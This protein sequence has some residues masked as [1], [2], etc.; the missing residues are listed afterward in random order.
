[1]ARASWI[2]ERR[3][4]LA[5]G[6]YNRLAGYD[7]SPG[8]QIIVEVQWRPYALISG[9]GYSAHQVGCPVL[10]AC[11]AHQVVFR[12]NPVGLAGR[13]DK[14]EKLLFGPDASPSGR[15][16]QQWKLRMMAQEA[17]LN[18]VAN[19]KLGKPLAYNKSF[20]CADVKIGDTALF[21]KSAKKKGAPSWRGPAKILDMSGATLRAEGGG[22]EGCGC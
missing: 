17:A 11:S 14:D 2:R 1:M 21:Y 10:G 3:N 15:F 7:C 9:G 16:A 18:E 5:R 22:R 4:G 13:D 19:C 12:S 20:N 6:I 8:E